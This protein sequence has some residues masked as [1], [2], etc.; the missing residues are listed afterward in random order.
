MKEWR[1]IYGWGYGEAEGFNLEGACPEGV[2][3]LGGY[4][5]FP[6]WLR[7]FFTIGLYSPRTV[8]AFPVASEEGMRK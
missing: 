2:A 6:N 5:S 3:Q 7:S 8:S 4:V 1:H